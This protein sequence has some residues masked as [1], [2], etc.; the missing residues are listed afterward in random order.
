MP[1]AA[2]QALS[3]RLAELEI[4]PAELAAIVGRE[5]EEGEDWIENGPSAKGKIMLR[6]L[7]ADADALRRVEQ[8]RRTFIRTW[9][10]DHA[11][12]RTATETVGPPVRDGARTGA[13]VPGFGGSK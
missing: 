11:A 5:V 6:F 7:A 10:G 13:V 3:D 9:A 1:K 12:Q 8:L 4:S 2:G